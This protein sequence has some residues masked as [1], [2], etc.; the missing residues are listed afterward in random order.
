MAN[1][2]IVDD[3]LDTADLSREILESAGHQI[4]TGNTGEEGLKSF[5]AAGLPD[6]VVLDVDMPELNGP[7]NANDLLKILA[8]A[9]TE[10]RAPTSA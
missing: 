4:Q 10:R 6:C 1:V 8:R 3:D 2:L 9:L 7:G 5:A